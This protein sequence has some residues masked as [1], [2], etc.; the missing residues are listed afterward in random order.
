M[1]SPLTAATGNI[2]RIGQ[3]GAGEQ[4]GDFR[5]CLFLPVDRS[6]ID[7][8]Q[9]HRAALDAE[10]FDDFQMLAGLRHRAVVGGDDQQREIDAGGA[11][12]H[13]VDQ[14]LVAGHVDEAE[15]CLGGVG[16]AEV[17]A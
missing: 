1:P 12:Q 5:F 6:S 13:V 17:D 15:H 10:Q 14:L 2:G 8:G 11:G 7:F 4:F 3:R 16:V 9:R